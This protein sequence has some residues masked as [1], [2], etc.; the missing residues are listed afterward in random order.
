MLNTGIQQI[1]SYSDIM[2]SKDKIV[3]S[4]CELMKDNAFEEIQVKEITETAKVN[5]STYYRNFNSK[6]DIIKYKLE[7]IMDEYIEE[8]ESQDDKSKQNYIYTILS[9]F[10]N[11]EDFFKTIHAQNQSYIL[12]KVLLDYFKTN[13]NLE[14]REKLYESYYHIGGIYNFTICWIENDM[15]DDIEYLSEIAAK[16]TENINPLYE[17]S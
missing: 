8:F 1:I 3:E 2:K 4:L 9:T 7:N 5:R 13:L 14:D 10:L 11:H 15:E 16:I 12:Q 6:E 17:I